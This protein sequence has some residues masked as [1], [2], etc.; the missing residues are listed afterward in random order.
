MS[1]I[2]FASYSTVHDLILFLSVS[3]SKILKSHRMGGLSPLI[4]TSSAPGILPRW[5]GDT[6]RSF[7]NATLAPKS[8][9]SFSYQTPLSCASQEADHWASKVTG[10]YRRKEPKS[11]STHFIY[12]KPNLL[13]EV[14][15]IPW[16]LLSQWC[17][18]DQHQVSW[19]PGQWDPSD[20]GRIFMKLQPGKV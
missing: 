12:Q 4:T 8:P 19:L 14:R 1:L 3:S 9:Q 10:C 11:L 6:R 13:L 7:W 16:L 2:A 20:H 15:W 5:W 18:E 17:T